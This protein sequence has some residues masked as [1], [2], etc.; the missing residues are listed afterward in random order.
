MDRPIIF[1]FALYYKILSAMEQFSSDFFQ[2]KT[3]LPFQVKRRRS[4][5]GSGS[6]SVRADV[7]GL[8]GLLSARPSGP[9]VFPDSVSAL[10]E[11]ETMLSYMLLS[12]L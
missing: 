2:A 12:Y 7:S 1:S 8:V 5:G 11:D 10:A 4:S 9:V 3:V 6:R